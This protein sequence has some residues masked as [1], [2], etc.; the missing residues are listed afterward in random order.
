MTTVLT[1]VVGV[2]I[3]MTIWLGVDLLARRQ[4]G[5]RERH[6]RAAQGGG[7]CGTCQTS[8]N[9]DRTGECD[10]SN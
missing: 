8:G 9:C 10:A 1:A 2:V 3:I 4:L 6:C 7:H 5:E